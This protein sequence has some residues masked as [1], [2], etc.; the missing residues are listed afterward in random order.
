MFSL[1]FF[2]FV[3]VVRCMANREERE[4]RLASPNNLSVYANLG[5]LLYTA[6]MKLNT[7]YNAWC[8]SNSG[9]FRNKVNLC[10]AQYG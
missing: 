7:I 2:I 10:F 8:L 9:G 3:G 5:L 6:E 4:L 1:P